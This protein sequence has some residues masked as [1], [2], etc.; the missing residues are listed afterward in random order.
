MV[1]DCDD[2]GCWAAGQRESNL[3]YRVICPTTDLNMFV[4]PQN[5]M[6]SLLSNEQASLG[7]Y[8]KVNS[9]NSTIDHPMKYQENMTRL[10]ILSWHVCRARLS[11]LTDATGQK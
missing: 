1:D 6:F 7:K 10:W 9:L 3:C 2:F 5:R 11:D 8:P 4:I